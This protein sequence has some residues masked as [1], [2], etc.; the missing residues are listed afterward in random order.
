MNVEKV[1]TKEIKNNI[2]NEKYNPLS[3]DD[4]IYEREGL[5]MRE[6]KDIVL[7]EIM[8]EL[9]FVERIFFKNKFIKVY[10]KG[11][12]KGFNWS[13]NIVR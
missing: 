11:V 13:N 8:E 9:N 12:R 3:V 5:F 2:I 4:K 10:K 6:T 7:D 1:F